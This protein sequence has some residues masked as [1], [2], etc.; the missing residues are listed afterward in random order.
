M[1][2]RPIAHAIKKMYCNKPIT[3]NAKWLPT[4]VYRTI[5]LLLEVFIPFQT[6]VGMSYICPPQNSLNL[7][8]QDL[9]QEKCPWGGGRGAGHPRARGP[10]CPEARARPRARPGG[11]HEGDPFNNRVLGL[12]R[13]AS[14]VTPPALGSPAG[15]AGSRGR[16]GVAGSS[17]RAPRAG[18]GGAGPRAGGRS[19]CRSPLRL[20]V[21][22]C[23]RAASR[24][25]HGPSSAGPR[26]RLPGC[27]VDRPGADGGGATAGGA[28]QGQPARSGGRGKARQAPPA[29]STGRPGLRGA[30]RGGGDDF[31]RAGRDSAGPWPRRSRL[32]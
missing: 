27:S 7:Q 24:K 2:L 26:R 17:R 9:G 23:G 29:E 10:P 25:P 5:F 6:Q 19:A 12:G 21:G 3:E 20:Q 18:L 4:G 13:G 31:L 11:S 8:T 16:P 14:A 22:L 15:V 28:A 32:R 30:A 1:V